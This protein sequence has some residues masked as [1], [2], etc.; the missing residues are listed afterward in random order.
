MRVTATSIPTP[1]PDTLVTASAVEN[2]GRANLDPLPLDANR[3]LLPHPA[4]QAPHQTGKAV[5]HL[6]HRRHAR[7]DDFVL[8]LTREAGDLN[9]DVVDRRVSGGGR[10]LVQPAAHR[11]E[12]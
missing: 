8:Q 10:E 2:P 6:P 9:R 7:L 5:E 12:L 11:D 3:A 1:R 4:G